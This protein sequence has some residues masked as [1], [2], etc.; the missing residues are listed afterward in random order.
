MREAVTVIMALLFLFGCA[1]FKN[2][3]EAAFSLEIVSMPSLLTASLENNEPVGMEI[4]IKNT[5]DP[6]V[7]PVSTAYLRY[8]KAEVY[9]QTLSFQSS[10]T[11]NMATEIEPGETETVRLVVLTLSE[12][13]QIRRL[14]RGRDSILSGS[15]TIVIH[16][17]DLFGK[18]YELKTSV[19]IELQ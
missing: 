5:S 9:F 8:Y 2:R 3:A 18:D 7:S 17:K 6:N 13:S 10:K 11:L 1:V 19:G 15:V 4:E 16:A 12:L 14:V